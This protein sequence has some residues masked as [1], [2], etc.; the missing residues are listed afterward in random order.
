MNEAWKEILLYAEV[1]EKRSGMPCRTGG[2]A[3][4]IGQEAEQEGGNNPGQSLYPGFHRKSKAGQG[5][6]CSTR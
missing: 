3:L 4:A 1:P 6:Q 5:K 2:E